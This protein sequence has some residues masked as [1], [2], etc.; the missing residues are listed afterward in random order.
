MKATASP[1]AKRSGIRYGSL[2]PE[3]LAAT[4]LL[5][6][7]RVL[8]TID[9]ADVTLSAVNGSMLSG[10]SKEGNLKSSSSRVA[11]QPA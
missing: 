5:P 10:G 8:V 4:S 7:M 11:I 3:A 1:A 6:P 2:L 9:R